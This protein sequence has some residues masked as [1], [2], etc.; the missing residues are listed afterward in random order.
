MSR[1]RSLVEAFA[2]AAPRYTADDRSRKLAL[3]DEL[4]GATVRD[5]GPLLRLH[6]ALCFLQAH[7]DDAKV[8]ELVDRA[9]ERFPARVDRLGPAARRKLHDSGVA[10]STL[11]Y[12]FGF[13]MARW[14]AAR[15][16]RE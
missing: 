11:D 14:L 1:G 8:L 3:L 7:P 6:E 2:A 4:D 9:L 16:P 13:P 10:G 15:F 12:P 5:A